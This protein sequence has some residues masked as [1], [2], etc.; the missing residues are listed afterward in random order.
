MSCGI[1]SCS[2][3]TQLLHVGSSSPTRD[4]NQDT[5][6]G[7]TFLATG[8]AGKSLESSLTSLLIHPHLFYVPSEPVFTKSCPFSIYM[9]SSVPSFKLP[10]SSPQFNPN[11]YCQCWIYKRG[12]FDPY[13]GKIPWRR[14]WQPTPVFL[15]GEFHGQRSLAGYS[16]WGHTELDTTAAT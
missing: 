5:C 15:S 3:W 14:A 11:W 6:F 16:P 13:A 9:I 10:L 8:P 1:F 4:W 7:S 2:T 12:G